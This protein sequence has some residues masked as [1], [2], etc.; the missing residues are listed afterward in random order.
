MEGQVP[1]SL[2]VQRVADC[3]RAV[4]VTEGK[5]ASGQAKALMILHTADAYVKLL[6]GSPQQQRRGKTSG[7][8]SRKEQRKGDP[9]QEEGDEHE[10]DGKADNSQRGDPWDQGRSRSSR[11]DCFEYGVGGT[12]IE[13]TTRGDATLVEILELGETESNLDVVQPKLM[14]REQKPKLQAEIGAVEEE[15]EDSKAQGVAIAYAAKMGGSSKGVEDKYFS[16]SP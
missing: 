12:R 10:V 7:R 4:G 11:T 8:T 9:A 16:L 5:K 13:W 1:G 6:I 15:L 14:Q 2:G 3:D